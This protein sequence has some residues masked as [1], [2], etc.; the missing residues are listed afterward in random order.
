MVVL[1]PALARRSEKCNGLLVTNY[2][3]FD[4]LTRVRHGSEEKPYKIIGR[5]GSQKLI[6]CTAII[7]LTATPRYVNQNKS[8]LWGNLDQKSVYS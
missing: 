5:P 3:N 2:P 1:Q 8:K 4:Q 7:I 6:C